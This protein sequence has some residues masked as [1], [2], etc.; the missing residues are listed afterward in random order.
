MTPA[1]P[2]LVMRG[3]I[4]SN[5]SRVRCGECA[6]EQPFTDPPQ[7]VA[8]K[9][10]AVGWV[11]TTTSGWCCPKCVPLPRLMPGELCRVHLKERGGA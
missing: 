10:V 4:L 3:R 9:A 1:T 7:T 11:F 8:A 6:A 2:T 5:P